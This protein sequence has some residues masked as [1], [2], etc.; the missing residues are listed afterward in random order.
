MTEFTEKDRPLLGR[1]MYRKLE[2]LGYMS[3]RTS[4]ELRYNDC[5]DSNKDKSKTT[6]HTTAALVHGTHGAHAVRAST[7]GRE[8]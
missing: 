6:R 5:T 1:V 3:P 8:L 4:L 2:C 7:V